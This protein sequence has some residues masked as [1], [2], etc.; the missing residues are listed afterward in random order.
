MGHTADRGNDWNPAVW[1]KEK[2]DVFTAP[3]FLLCH[4][5]AWDA[6][7][8]L[9]L[10]I[11]IQNHTARLFAAQEV[12][13]SSNALQAETVGNQITQSDA[14]VRQEV[15]RGCKSLAKYTHQLEFLLCKYR[16]RNF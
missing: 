3:V 2:A 1:Q 9:L 6:G 12:K 7:G 15:S 16:R 14:P 4:C 11:W 5:V 8:S 10:T 13:R